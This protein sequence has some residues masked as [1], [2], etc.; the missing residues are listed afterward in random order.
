MEKEYIVEFKDNTRFITDKRHDAD[1]IFRKVKKDVEKYY[2][3]AEDEVIV[4]Y[5]GC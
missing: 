5:G 4:L 1:K 3:K 2:A